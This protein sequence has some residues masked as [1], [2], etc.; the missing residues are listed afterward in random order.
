MKNFSV[1]PEW[2]EVSMAFSDFG[3]TDG[4][5]IMAILFSAS[6]EAGPFQFFIDDVRLE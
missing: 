6:T 3:G 5:D 1:G 2:K 4:H